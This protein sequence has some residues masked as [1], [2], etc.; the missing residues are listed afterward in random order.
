[1]IDSSTDFIETTEDFKKMFDV[2]RD[3]ILDD[4]LELERIGEEKARQEFENML[5]TQTTTTWETTS[6]EGY[7]STPPELYLGSRC[8]VPICFIVFSAIDFLGRIIT[9]LHRALNETT[10]I[11]SNGFAKH[12]QL[13]FY[14]LADK[15]E[16]VK[17][18][19]AKKLES[20][21]RHS[22]LHS[23]LPSAA[24]QKSGYSVAFLHFSLVA[25][26]LFISKN[27]NKKTEVLNVKFLTGVLK[28][29]L[30]KFED[31]IEKGEYTKELIVEYNNYLQEF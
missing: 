6:R 29:G 9:P 15:H 28:D 1:M 14:Y 24:N 3:Y 8:T 4:L 20:K 5:K 7:N 2:Y 26:T 11:G 13:F 27:D 23:F 30:N 16:L 25:N 10:V 31:I 18:D 17:D 19:A 21:Y 12:A 22:I